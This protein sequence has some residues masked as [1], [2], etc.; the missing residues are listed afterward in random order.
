ML[1]TKAS[2]SLTSNNLAASSMALEAFW[3][4]IISYF[5]SSIFQ[6]FRS[7]LKE[8]FIHDLV[9]GFNEAKLI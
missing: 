6:N 4:N 5:P 1:Y 3:Q 7:L 9:C 2:P 8:F